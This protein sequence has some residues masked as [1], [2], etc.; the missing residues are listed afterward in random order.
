[1]RKLFLPK[2]RRGGGSAPDVLGD[3]RPAPTEPRQR[4]G[5][6]D[7]SKETST[8]SYKTLRAVPKTAV[9]VATGAGAIVG[10]VSAVATT[11]LVLKPNLSASTEN[12]VEISDVISESNV[13]LD[14]YLRH[15]PVSRSLTNSADV[16]RLREL[17]RERLMSPGTVVHFQFRVVGYRS[18]RMATR[19]SLFDAESRR[20]V[21]D[22]E[23]VD[24]LPLVF[25]AQK[26][27]TDVGTWEVWVDTSAHAGRRLFVRI[28]LYDDEVGTRV[29]YKESETFNP[30]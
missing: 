16:S 13:T 1:M 4:D 30:D 27:D 17:N 10:L 8:G 2:W 29:A 12:R 19:W 28:E 25:N 5:L 7:E 23:G 20:R 14:Q 18:K 22:S 21:L 11:L 15:Q 24:P 26:R 6:I 3:G 9:A